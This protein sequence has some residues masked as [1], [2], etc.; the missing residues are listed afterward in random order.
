VPVIPAVRDYPPS[1]TA[2]PRTYLTRRERQALVLAA[3][4]YTNQA[5]ARQLGVGLETVK[6]R[7]KSILAK[8]RV[9]DRAQAVAVGLKLG[10]I[11]L[12][13]VAVPEGANR[14]YRDSA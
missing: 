3:N 13:E 9:G 12:D 1:L 4:G 7:M 11:G 2:V 6:T 5:I 14:G 8:L 10:L